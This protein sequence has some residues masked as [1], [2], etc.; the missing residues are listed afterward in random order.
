MIWPSGRPSE[1]PPLWTGPGCVPKAPWRLRA[2]PNR[3]NP[4][5]RWAASRRALSSQ[6]PRV[7]LDGER[8]FLAP[9]SRDHESRPQGDHLWGLPLVRRTREA[10]SRGRRNSGRRVR[11]LLGDGSLCQV[12]FTK[13]VRKLFAAQGA[14]EIASPPLGSQRPSSLQTAGVTRCGEAGCLGVPAGGAGGGPQGGLLSSLF[15]E[16]QDVLW[17]PTGSVSATFL[18]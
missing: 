5:A 3:I 9:P 13:S 18:E 2:W 11:A 17:D 16:P 12:L 4:V 15:T 7:A 8:G 14:A 6:P 1:T 10:R